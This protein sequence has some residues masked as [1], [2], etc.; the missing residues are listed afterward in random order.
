MKRILSFV[1]ACLFMVAC[2]SEDLPIAEDPLTK[3]GAISGSCT[4]SIGEASDASASYTVEMKQN[5]YSGV[6]EKI[7]TFRATLSGV[8][9]PHHA[10]TFRVFFYKDADLKEMALIDSYI[11]NSLTLEIDVTNYLESKLYVFFMTPGECSSGDRGLHGFLGEA[12]FDPYSDT[13]SATFAFKVKNGLSTD[14]CSYSIG[15]ATAN[16]TV[17]MKQNP[18]TGTT[19]KIMTFNASISGVNSHHA[20]SFRVFFFKDAE[21]KEQLSWEGYVNNGT[22]TMEMNV[23]DFKETMFY[24]RMASP[25][26]CSTGDYNTKHYFFGEAL[27]YPYEDSFTQS[28]NIV[29]VNK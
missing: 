12:N 14:A 6:M 29:T 28:F 9:D 18:N 8:R 24:V 10:G 17:A 1:C 22:V 27:F 16:Y 3:A 20:G 26:E 13:G 19:E 7:M 15:N 2:S 21:Q 25:Y 4:Y 23:D 5:P 11:T